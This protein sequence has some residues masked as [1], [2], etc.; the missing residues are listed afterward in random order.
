MM[1]A[2]QSNSRRVRQEAVAVPKYHGL[3]LSYRLPSD[4][5]LD[6]R[7]IIALAAVTALETVQAG[8]IWL[9]NESQ[10]DVAVYST[11]ECTQW[12]SRC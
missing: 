10:L 2:V 9:T 3:T 12:I 8:I 1:C 4:R 5:F 6:S 11:R 7:A